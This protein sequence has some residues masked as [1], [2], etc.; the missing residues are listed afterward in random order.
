MVRALVLLFTLLVTASCSDTITC[1]E[2]QLSPC[3]PAAEV[4]TLLSFS[5]NPQPECGLPMDFEKGPPSDD[6][7]A[8]RIWYETMVAEIPALEKAWQ[9][10]G[11]DTAQRARCAFSIRHNARLRARQAMKD[12]SQ[13]N[14]LEKRDLA[15]YGHPDGPTFCWL[16][17]KNCRSGKTGTALYEAIIQSAARTN[18]A[19]HK[20]EKK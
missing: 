14:A 17:V 8:I 9:E 10:A 18:P 1:S 12:P 7:E 19:F 2:A 15:K 20:S 5:A 4:A 6:N 11:I 3:L 13:V 16:V